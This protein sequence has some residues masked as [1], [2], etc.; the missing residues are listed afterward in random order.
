MELQLEPVIEFSS[1]LHCPVVRPKKN[2][3][4]NW[5]FKRRKFDRYDGAMLELISIQNFGGLM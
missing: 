4:E 2:K 3:K 1:R 5:F